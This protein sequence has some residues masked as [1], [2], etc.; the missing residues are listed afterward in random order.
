MMSITG[1]LVPEVEKTRVVWTQCSTSLIH[2]EV[3]FHGPEN[4]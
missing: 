1:F 3:N 2:S 4:D